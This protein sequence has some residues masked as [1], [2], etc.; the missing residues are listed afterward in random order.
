M[1]GSVARAA[2]EDAVEDRQAR[3]LEGFV[4]YNLKRAYMLF[5]TDFR[6][7]LG[8]DGL[9]PRAFSVL[10]LVVETPGITQSDLSRHL[11]IERSGLVAI[12]DD[13]QRRGYLERRPVPGD[14]R[15]QALTPTPAGSAAY[16]EMLAAIEAHEEKLLGGFDAVERDTLLRLLGKFR[17]LHGDGA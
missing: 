1:A 2:R 4:G 17:T 5:Q 10:S 11:G 6:Q 7:T 14:R 8:E 9:T 16:D 3:A 13:L 12:T 15:V